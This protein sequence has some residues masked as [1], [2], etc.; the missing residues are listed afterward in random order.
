[1]RVIATDQLD[2]GQQAFAQGELAD[3]VLQHAT[4]AEKLKKVQEDLAK[5]TSEYHDAYKK[6][7]EAQESNDAG[8]GDLVAAQGAQERMNKLMVEYYNISHAV[9][10][11]RK[12]YSEQLASI[13]EQV[14]FYG[15]TEEEQLS[16]L[17]T[18]LEE[19]NRELFLRRNLSEESS[20]IMVGGIR[21]EVDLLTEWLRLRQQIDGMEKKGN[22]PA[23]RDK[24]AQEL[25]R[26]IS[27]ARSAFETLR[28]KFDEVGHSLRGMNVGIEQMDLLKAQV[29]ANKISAEEYAKAVY[30][31]RLAH[32]E[33]VAAQQKHDD[34]LTKLRDSYLQSPFSGAINDLATLNRLLDEG[35]IKAY[36]YE[37]IRAQ[38]AQKNKE[39]VLSSLP[40]ADF[41]FEGASA[42]P[43]NEWARAEMERAKGMQQ[44]GKAESGLST[45][46]VNEQMLIGAQFEE[47][48]RIE[49]EQHLLRMEAAA[50]FRELELAAQIEHDEKIIAL[51]EEKYTR[52]RGAHETFN[53][54][55]VALTE[56]RA[57]Y[58]QQMNHMVM[59]GM[60]STAQGILGMFA[61]VGDQATTAQKLAFLAQ[62][63]IA[64]A[65]I[66]MQT[67]VAAANAKAMLP[68]GVGD[69]MAVKIMA[70]GYAS[71]GMVGGLAI[72]KLAT[73]GEGGGGYAGAYDKGGWIPAGK[74]GVVGEYGPE[75]V[76]GPA[77]V[78]GRERTASKYGS[79]GGSEVTIAPQINVTVE[80]QEGGEDSAE[81][82]GKVLAETINAS[83][84]TF[85]REQTRPNGMLD[86]WVRSRS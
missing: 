35:K 46:L 53:E 61:A 28:Q 66:L 70:L 58:E 8:L 7:Q 19:V 41:Q 69:A 36:E 55:S 68:P 20:L 71:A 4:N 62:Q 82:Y 6:V 2:Y 34:S 60:M 85:F 29:D 52:I 57:D 54:A 59:M 83:I 80:A 43:L 48:M 15:M 42:T 9:N 25:E 38:I 75:M 3:A 27:Q 1:M 79:G 65:Q 16:H 50:G 64:V 74:W 26:R 13:T 67:H 24:E 14:A 33:V 56:Q 12:R 22:K 18:K 45:D 76:H 30:Q 40:Q 81:R 84:V 21:T 73:G 37:A 44:F 86:S 47:K 11:E 32:L 17:Q 78:T 72:A 23:G 31:L 39:Q 5:A 51:E 10:E 77:H 63:G 49:E